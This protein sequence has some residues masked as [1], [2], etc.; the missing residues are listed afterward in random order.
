MNTDMRMTDGALSVADAH[1]QLTKL[2]SDFDVADLLEEAI[3]FLPVQGPE[4]LT[5][6]MFDRIQPS[7]NC[8]DT[9]SEHL[10]NAE[11][12]NQELEQ[13]NDDEA[14]K[15]AKDHKKARTKAR[16][17]IPAGRKIEKMKKA[18]FHD[19]ESANLIAGV[20]RFGFGQSKACYQFSCSSRLRPLQFRLHILVSVSSLLHLADFALLSSLDEHE[21]HYFQEVQNLTPNPKV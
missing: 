18:H 15:E 13:T 14:E 3:D 7:E 9:G 4:K 21:H 6:S 8:S 19:Y 12:R 1:K 17:K 16:A 10:K 5:D 2:L 11:E 20:E